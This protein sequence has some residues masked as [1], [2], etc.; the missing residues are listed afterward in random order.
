M[1]EVMGSPLSVDDNNLNTDVDLHV[2]LTC[3]RPVDPVVLE[4]ICQKNRVPW[5]HE[6]YS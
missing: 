4:V 3:P 5:W 2:P 6:L 1:T